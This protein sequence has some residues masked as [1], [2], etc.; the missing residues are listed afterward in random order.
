VDE[1]LSS[2][3]ERVASAAS[4]RG[5][6][7]V[8]L[9]ALLCPIAHAHPQDDGLDQ[10]LEASGITSQVLSIDGQVQQQL[11]TNP[12]LA[13]LPAEDAA[14]VRAAVASSF[15]GQDILQY[16]RGEVAQRLKG[17]D[18][19]AL[20]K[21]YADPFIKRVTALEKAM[22]KP[23]VP[24]QVQQYA[25]KLQ[26]APAPASRVGLIGRLDQKVGGSDF[27][28]AVASS[29]ITGMLDGINRSLDP[30]RQLSPAALD[31]HAEKALAQIRQPMA[32]FMMVSYLYAYRSLNDDELERYVKAYD[33]PPVSKLMSGFK[34]G[35]L[36]G[37]RQSSLSVG[38]AV[39]TL[40]VPPPAGK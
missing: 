22:E 4:W 5:L 33:S 9:L 1:E 39:S 17:N 28:Y 40:R 8:A 16:V 20:R 35:F 27:A 26:S 24:A 10:V 15:K 32:N 2:R 12:D 30:K 6:T 29:T 11:A 19:E 31:K 13:R 38:R 23:D 37:L 34:A 21:F 7:F 25:R 36:R 14:R 3:R 18:I